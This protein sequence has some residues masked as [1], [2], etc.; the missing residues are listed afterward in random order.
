MTL[1]CSCTAFYHFLMD[2]TQIQILPSSRPQLTFL[3]PSSFHFF[4]LILVRSSLL[5]SF[6]V[7][8]S[9][10]AFPL[11]LYALSVPP[12]QWLCGFLHLCYVMPLRGRGHSNQYFKHPGP[13]RTRFK[14]HVTTWQ[15][16][17]WRRKGGR[18]RERERRSPKYLLLP[19]VLWL[20]GGW[21]WLGGKKENENADERRRN[22]GKVRIMA[23]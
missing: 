18:Q 12:S 19:A 4:P 8:P 20:K 23:R 16:D 21:I 6:T 22:L 14:C 3:Y 11:S 5:C 13:W 15:D 2:E 9:L 1:V 17:I 7:S 10:R